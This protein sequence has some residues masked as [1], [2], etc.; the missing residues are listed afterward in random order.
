MSLY[1]V[2]MS[3]LKARINEEYNRAGLTDKLRTMQRIYNARIK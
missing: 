1:Q 3:E 2:P